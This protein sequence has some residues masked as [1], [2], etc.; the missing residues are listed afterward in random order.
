MADD[1]KPAVQ[2][3]SVTSDALTEKVK[4]AAALRTA[5]KTTL[6]NVLSGLASTVLLILGYLQTVNIGSV[7]TPQQALLWIVGVNVLTLLLRAVGTKPIVLDRDE[8]RFEDRR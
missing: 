8:R 3:V 5:W 7:V 4:P 6:L 2:A 1:S